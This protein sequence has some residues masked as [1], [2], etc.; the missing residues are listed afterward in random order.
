MLLNT[1]V[2]VDTQPT[3]SLA[4][5]PAHIKVR[6][7]FTYELL[8]PGYLTE[9]VSLSNGVTG[10]RGDEKRVERHLDVG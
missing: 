2:A 6:L 7:T 10:E 9:T 1:A 5:F 8:A 3:A 4:I